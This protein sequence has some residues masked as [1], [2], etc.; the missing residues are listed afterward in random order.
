MGAVATLLLLCAAH[1]HALLFGGPLARRPPSPS[2]TPQRVVC[3]R[4]PRRDVGPPGLRRRR[5]LTGFFVE[6][7]EF[8]RTSRTRFYQQLR[9]P[10]EDEDD[11]EPSLRNREPLSVRSAVHRNNW[12]NPAYRNATLAKR[13]ETITQR[14]LARTGGAAAAPPPPPRSEAAV[15]KA[16][17]LQLLHVNEAAWM[18]QWLAAGEMQ[19]RRLSDDETRRAEKAWRSELARE[20]H[21]RAGT[22]RSPDAPPAA[23]PPRPPRP[24]RPPR[25]VPEGWACVEHVSPRGLKY[26]RY[27][28]PNGQRAQLLKQAWEVHLRSTAQPL[29]RRRRTAKAPP[30]I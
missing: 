2:R 27:T 3:G 29:R 14:R 12:A 9:P 5:P 26:K 17:A 16:E 10:D 13:N 25:P 19:R 22:A 7:P 28:G 21:R 1:A 30:N 18:Q 15:E 24:A 8:I 4:P 20:R 11:Y 23:E 6:K